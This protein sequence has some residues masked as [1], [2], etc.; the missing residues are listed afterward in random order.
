MP[1]D[2][3]RE[4]RPKMQVQYVP[5]PEDLKLKEGFTK[6]KN[7][8]K[9]AVAH[10]VNRARVFI[11]HPKPYQPKDAEGEIMRHEKWGGWF[12][13][14]MTDADHGHQMI[15]FFSETQKKKD[16][17]TVEW[18]AP[19]VVSNIIRHCKEVGLTE[20]NYGKFLFVIGKTAAKAG[21]QGRWY[22]ELVSKTA[23]TPGMFDDP[24]AP[25]FS[26]T[27]FELTEDEKEIVKKM[28]SLIE[29]NGLPDTFCKDMFLTTFVSGSV[30]S[31][32]TEKRALQIWNLAKEDNEKVG[33]HP[34]VV[35]YIVGS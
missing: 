35:A 6:I 22:V 2:A 30:G 32:T 28:N 26:A 8:K 12:S 18:Q 19:Y 20:D 25:R 33:L 7:E 27:I 11:E 13:W 15:V 31:P 9:G 3:E 29:E 4:R 16:D 1:K 10:Y 17:G 14:N 21:N 23:D 5:D 24:T 34:D